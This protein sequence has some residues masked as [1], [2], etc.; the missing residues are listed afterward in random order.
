MAK[1]SFYRPLVKMHLHL[2]LSRRKIKFS[3]GIIVW[4]RLLQIAGKEDP[5]PNLSQL[6]H[7]NVKAG[8]SRF[9]GIFRVPLGNQG[10]MQL[11]FGDLCQVFLEPV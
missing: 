3:Q 11:R 2:S 1:L 7:N 9:D 6:P 8:F 5:Q 4:T 10:D